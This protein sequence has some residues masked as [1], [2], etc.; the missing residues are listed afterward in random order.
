MCLDEFIL[1]IRIKSAG[2]GFEPQFTGMI[3]VDKG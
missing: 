1:D 2:K 3:F